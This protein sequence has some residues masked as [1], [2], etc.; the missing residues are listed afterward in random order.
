MKKLKTLINKYSIAILISF[1]VAVIVHLPLFTKNILTADVLLNTGYYSGYSWEISLG[2]FGLY[3]IGL[4]KSFLVIPQVEIFISILLFLGVMIIIFELFEIKNKVI[5]VLCGILVS[6][7]PILSAT[8]LFHYCSLA[9]ALAF[10]SSVLAVYLFIKAKGKMVKYFVPTFLISFSLSMYQAYLAIP[11]TLLLLWWMVQILRKKFTWKEFFYSFGIVI[12]GAIFYFIL[13][14]LSL[15][16]FH[17]DLSSYRGASQFGIESILNIPSR[18]FDAYR[19]FYQFYFTDDI[20]SNSNLF[21][22]IFYIIM[23]CLLFFGI[24]YSLYKNK[25]SFKYSLLFMVFFLLIPVFVNISVIIFPNTNMQLLMSGGYLLI[26]F[27]ICYFIQ[28][29]KLLIIFTSFIFIILIRGYI[30]QDSATYQTLENT[31]KKT[32]QI[33]SDIRSQINKMGYTREIMIAG[34]LDKNHYYTKKSTTEF[35]RL[36][37]YTYGFVSNY[38]LFWDEYTNM[39]NGWSRFMEYELGVSITFVSSDTYQKILDSKDYHNMKCYPSDDSIQL[40]DDVVV[41]K[42]AD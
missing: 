12:L 16:V 17:V 22:Q 6:V 11:F 19:N 31:Y 37:R 1:V 3:I 13:M 14:K 27:F 26:F 9:Y 36:S 35:D 24:V 38:S 39:K 2:R 29:Q 20:V 7:S 33:A 30:I 21:M 25:V 34:N 10:F 5:Q 4:L 8:F 32:Y 42:L 41:V 18:I 15:I 40:I 23:F 28:D